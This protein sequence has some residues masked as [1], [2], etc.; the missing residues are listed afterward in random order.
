[1][2]ENGFKYEAFI[3]RFS[4]R[5]MGYNVLIYHYYHMVPLINEKYM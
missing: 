3:M 5:N 4:E 2:V 1:M